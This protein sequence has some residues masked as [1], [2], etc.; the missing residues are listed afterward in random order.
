MKIEIFT[1]SKKTCPSACLLRIIFRENKIFLLF[2]FVWSE[3]LWTP[4]I[5]SIHLGHEHFAFIPKSETIPR[6]YEFMWSLRLFSG[7]LFVPVFRIEHDLQNVSV[8]WE[9]DVFR[10]YTWWHFLMTVFIQLTTLKGKLNSV[11]EFVKIRSWLFLIFS[12]YLQ[13]QL[14]FNY[15]AFYFN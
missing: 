13:N 6:S 9:I 14:K 2:S 10:R 1:H 15:R 11:Q 4:E 7:K 3:S 12:K 8:F 5:N